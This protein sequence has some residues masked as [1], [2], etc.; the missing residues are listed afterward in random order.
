[1]LSP[2]LLITLDAVLF[3][4]SRDLRLKSPSR[5]IPSSGAV[6]DSAPAD[7][8]TSTAVKRAGV[9]LPP[10]GMLLPKLPT[11]QR[12]RAAPKKRSFIK[13]WARFFCLNLC[14]D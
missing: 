8:D 12:K 1:M 5:R 3:P 11:I 7:L 10:Q 6:G 13:F 14:R 9:S 4:G 2:S